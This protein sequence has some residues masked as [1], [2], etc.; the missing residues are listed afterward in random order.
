MSDD[1]VLR[2]R[3]LLVLLFVIGAGL[4]ATVAVRWPIA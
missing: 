2:A 3:R 4:G 1:Q